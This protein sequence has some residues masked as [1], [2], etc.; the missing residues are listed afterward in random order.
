MVKAY[1]PEALAD[2]PDWEAQAF[3]EISR[4]IEA[5]AKISRDILASGAA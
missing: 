4:G 5:S 1:T 3:R 2:Y